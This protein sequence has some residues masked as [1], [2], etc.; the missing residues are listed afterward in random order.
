MKIGWTACAAAAAC[1]CLGGCGRQGQD[2]AKYQIYYLAKDGLSLEAEGYNTDTEDTDSLVEELF[3]KMDTEPDTNEYRTARP[4]NVSV[5]GYSV[6]DGFLYIDYSA[7]YAAMDSVTEVLYRAAVVKTLSQIPGIEGVS[8]Q[9]AGNPLTLKNGSTVGVMTAS[10]F[11][12]NTEETINSYSR[13][14]LTLYF[15]SDTA[16]D[17]LKGERVEV[18][19]NSNVSMERL[20][21][22]QLIEGP[23][24]EGY[25][26][27]LPENVKVLNISVNEGV[28]YVN[29]DENIR[30]L[31]GDV[32]ED[33]CIY[34]IVNSLTEIS[35]VSKVQISINGEVDVVLRESR[36]LNK[37]FERN[38]DIVEE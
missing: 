26:A 11:V 31:S 35:G 9:V 36:S 2:A 33:M 37:Q 18:T 27:T 8:I 13:A 23:K 5:S 7:E 25:R 29:L 1:L 20:I 10:D 14:T 3:E 21:M 4:S 16:D 24:A 22:E 28:C 19:Y 30:S 15:L 32:S 6:E 17:K 12:D 38:L 34:S